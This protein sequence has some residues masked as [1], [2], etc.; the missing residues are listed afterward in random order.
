M[1]DKYLK[2]E[3][4]LLMIMAQYFLRRINNNFLV[5]LMQQ[6]NVILSS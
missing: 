5:S 2:N 4:I 3:Y 6:F 1:K